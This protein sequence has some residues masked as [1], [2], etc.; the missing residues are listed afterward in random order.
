VSITSGEATSNKS[1]YPP[2]TR[3]ACD[4]KKSILNRISSGKSTSGSRCSVGAALGTNNQ[5]TILPESSTSHNLVSASSSNAKVPS[6]RIISEAFENEA[7]ILDFFSTH[8]LSCDMASSCD[9]LI[10]LRIAANFGFPAATQLA[11]KYRWQCQRPLQ[12]LRAAIDA[13][14]KNC[15]VQNAASKRPSNSPASSKRRS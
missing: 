14:G 3:N 11:A 9:E 4:T 13:H 10:F 1:R 6:T 7:L 12:A 8:F 15:S 5:R 2:G